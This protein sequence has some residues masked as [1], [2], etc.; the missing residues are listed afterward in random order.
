MPQN[1]PAHTG[2]YSGGVAWVR[3]PP[4]HWGYLKN[5]RSLEMVTSLYKL[6]LTLSECLNY[7]VI[8]LIVETDAK[9]YQSPK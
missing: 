7:Y 9:I 4:P 3:V 2:T 5:L 8:I 6:I 1:R